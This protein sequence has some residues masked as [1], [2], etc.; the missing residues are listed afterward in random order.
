MGKTDEILQKISNLKNE[1]IELK[2]DLK[3][4]QERIDKRD[5]LDHYEKCDLMEDL[6]ETRLKILNLE[7]QI[8]VLELGKVIK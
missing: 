5:Y 1:L 7:K 6:R 4:T 8:K 2:E 3:E